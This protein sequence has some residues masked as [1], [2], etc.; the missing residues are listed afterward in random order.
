MEN[1][2]MVAAELLINQNSSLITL[3]INACIL[4]KEF[5]DF[6]VQ[7]KNI[8]CHILHCRQFLKAKLEYCT[9]GETV[10]IEKS[11]NL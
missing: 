6:T 9:A 5:I 2:S 7:L 1:H 10:K 11:C 8:Y 3:Q 4:N